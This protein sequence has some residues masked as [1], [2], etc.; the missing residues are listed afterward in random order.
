MRHDGGLLIALGAGL[1]FLVSVYNYFVP[2]ALL[3]P[4]SNVSG[5]PG[6]IL[7]IG[8][9][10]ILCI[11][12]LVLAGTAAGRGLAAF[13]IL[14]SLVGILGT[15]LVAWLLDSTLLVALMLVCLVGWVLRVF[16]RHPAL[17]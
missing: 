6:A 17:V 13:L 1:G 16:T 8:A 10:A 14:G 15:G 7:A 4:T 12:G 5:T 2:V 3:A 11:A 9:T